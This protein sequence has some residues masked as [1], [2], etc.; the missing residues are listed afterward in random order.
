MEAIKKNGLSRWISIILLVNIPC[1]SKFEEI[2]LDGLSRKTDLLVKCERVRVYREIF[3]FP[4][5]KANQNISHT[6]THTN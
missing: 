4:T 2:N 6:H 1:S 5:G 3:D